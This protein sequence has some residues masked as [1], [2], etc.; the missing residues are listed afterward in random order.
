MA[1]TIKS[2]DTL[3]ALAAKYGTT[4]S[5]IQKLNPSITDI[6]KIYAGQSLNLPTITSTISSI[7]KITTPITTSGTT[8]P[9]II[10][11]TTT[12]TINTTSQVIQ[13]PINPNASILNPN[14]KAPVN[15]AP[16]PAPVPAPVQ[17]PTQAPIQNSTNQQSIDTMMAE[18]AKLQ[19]LKDKLVS[20]GGTNIDITTG[21]VAKENIGDAGE[22]IHPGT[23][24]ITNDDNL[25]FAE[26]MKQIEDYYSGKTDPTADLKAQLA[27]LQTQ[28]NQYQTDIANAKTTSGVAGAQEAV[29][30]TTQM[31]D[32]LE[33]NI[34]QRISGTGMT[35]AQRQRQ[36]GVEQKPL[37]K[38]LGTQTNAL[39]LAQQ[40]YNNLI[41]QAE[42]PM[43]LTKSMLP[44]Y[45]SLANYQSPQQKM[46]D[47]IAQEMMQKELGLGDYYQTPEDTTKSYETL[48]EGQT[49]I[50]LATGQVIYQAPKTSTGKADYSGVKEVRGGLFDIASGQWLVPPKTG[51]EEL[52]V[53]DQI[54]L[55][56]V[57]TAKDSAK[58]Q[59]LEGYSLANELEKAEIG[60]ITGIWQPNAIQPGTDAAYAKNKFDQL[61]GILKIEN[62]QK[63]KG[64]GTITDF[65]FKILAEA[66][67]AIG[68]NLS[69]KQ[70]RKELAKIKG[71]FATAS[72]MDANVKVMKNGSKVDEGLLSREEIQDA[73][74]QGYE[75][76]YQ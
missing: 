35:E 3:S 38:T 11:K 2:G 72:G 25:S 44:Y 58:A 49:L 19:A 75:I 53:T 29:T 28:M 8:T 23:S 42:V 34:N 57:S 10:P 67:S 64:Q 74:T 6:N 40:N 20:S 36:Y 16:A 76:I 39:T 1:Y 52:S 51:T 33:E 41:N 22:Q 68:R 59:A 7:P 9:S 31:L 50:D 56:E 30:K 61:V 73:I 32:A 4:T 24:N 17:P 21:E 47:M 5:A 55:Q 26:K 46:Q 66:A 45:Q 14:Y 37:T 63:L 65:E 54:K 48:S 13:S 62:R 43:E 18:V 70:F 12:P 71:V 69:E 15:V 27:T 60:G